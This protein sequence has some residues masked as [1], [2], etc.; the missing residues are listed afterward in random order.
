MVLLK[1]LMSLDSILNHVSL[2]HNGK[3]VP[4]LKQALC[5]MHGGV[6][7]QLH[8]FLNSTLDGGG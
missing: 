6:K 4:V 2:V 7:V 3:V 8:A 5:Q 1:K